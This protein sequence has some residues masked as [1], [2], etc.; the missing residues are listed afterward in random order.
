MEI[1]LRT[2]I[3][4]SPTGMMHVGTARTA[5][6]NW[7]AARASG[8]EFILRIDDTDQDRN[9]E[10]M[11]SPILDG[12]TWL[13]LNWDAIYRQ[14]ERAD[15]YRR[16][17]EALLLAG[18]AH[19]E[20]NGAITLKWDDDM[21]RI[22]TD[23][24]V[25]SVPISSTMIS[26]IDRRLVLIRGGEKL[27]QPTYQ[28]ASIVDDY[29]MGVNMVIRG[30]DH[31]ANTAKQ[32]AIWSAMTRADGRSRILPRFAHVGLIF[33][34]GRKM[35]KRDGASSLL[36]Y[37]DSGVH[38]DALFNFLL[39]LGWGPREDN[40]ENSVLSR[41]RAVSLFLCG[42]RMRSAS[43]SFDPVK[44]AWYDRRFKAM[45][46]KLARCEDSRPA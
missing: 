14:S 32:V 5:L 25:G 33:H 37:R 22:W 7:L 10:E 15:I 30:T 16:W 35:S 2:R 36:D 11:I 46:E 44:L 18:F 42:G 31:I 9:R 26:Q 17:A 21:P 6:F 24:I 12:L 34:G 4:P 41:E 27:G 8:G 38:P 45:D 1:K 3:A 20:D 40:R 23:D 39:R 43:A 13:G 19:R 28:F 29:E